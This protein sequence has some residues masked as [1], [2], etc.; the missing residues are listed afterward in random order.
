MK[1]SISKSQITGKV[2][3]PPTKSYT[4]RGLMCAALTK[5]KSEIIH[6]LSSD[7]TE[8]CLNVLSKV[9]IRVYQKEDSWQ[10]E[11]SD[12]REP[13]TD[14]FCGESAATLRFMTAICSLVPGKCRLIAGPSLSKRP[15]TP[16]LQALRQLGVIVSTKRQL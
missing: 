9:G 16:L 12:F 7:D 4:I 6:P 3:A 1:A 10:V 2:I 15:I 14:L 5:G 11:G 13:D 8:A